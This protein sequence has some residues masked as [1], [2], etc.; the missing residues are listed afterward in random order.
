MKELD[1]YFLIEYGDHSLNSKWNLDKGET[2]VISSQS[3]NNGCY[4][5]YD[6]PITH[7][8]YVISVPRTGSIGYAFVQNHSCSIDDNCLVLTPRD[9]YSL[10]YLFYISY[11]IR[12]DKW[13]FRYGRQ[14]TPSRLGKMMVKTPQEFKINISY[15]KIF[16]ELY[17]NKNRKNY[18]PIK[19]SKFSNFNIKKLF[20]IDRG[21]FHAID[22]LKPGKIPTISR[23]SDNNGLVGF[24]K[25]P[26]NA[27]LYKKGI[28]T[29][30]TVTGDAFLQL[31]HFIATD[32]VLIL[33]PKKKFQLTTLFYIVTVLNS[34]KWRYSYGRQ[35]YKRIFEKTDIILP[36]DEQNNLDE[37]YMKSIIENNEYW[38][39]LKKQLKFR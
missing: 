18:S 9:R 21:D 10:E 25:K 7:D 32:N 6:V 19:P 26:S 1:N 17:P 39:Y 23:I 3:T 37:K 38:E 11:M 20:K 24:Y 30:S 2:L 15:T 4:G 27:Q 35:P 36:V 14:I 29:I 13:R 8:T 34:Y 12:K 31:N 33:N 28:I 22:R 16:N 5:F